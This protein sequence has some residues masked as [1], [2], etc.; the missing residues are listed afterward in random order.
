MLTERPEWKALQAHRAAMENVH[1]RGLFADQNRFDRFH[2]KS[3]GLLFDYSR[4]RATDET[5]KLLLNLAKACKIESW[6]DRMFSGDK[7][8]NSEDRAVLHTALRRPAG[9]DVSV[10]GENVMPFI[11]DT[12]R[13]MQ[14]FSKAV[15]GGLWTGHT[16]QKIKTIIN[17][18]IGGSDLGPL[19]VCEALAHLPERMDVRFVS[20][21]DGA[22]LN[23]TL[24]GLDPATTLFVIASKTFTTQETMANAITARGWLINAMQDTKA[25][26]K[27]FVALSTNEKAVAEFGIAPENMFPFR[28][29][30]GGRYSLWSAIGLSICLAYGFDT[31]RALLA[32]G[33]EM[34]R[35]F[36]EE[37]LEGNMPVIMA[38][39]GL[40]YRNFWD[41]QSYAVLPYAQELHRLPAFLQQLDM[42]S[43]GKSVDRDG[44]PLSYATGPVLLGEPG[45]N[46]QHSFMQLIHQGTNF[47]PCDF[48]GTL[49]APIAVG[50][51]HKLLL[52]NMAA[53]AQALMHGRTAEEAGGDTRRAFSGNRPSNILLLD[54][55]D[56]RH[57]GMLIALYEHKVFAQG[58]LWNINS[59]DQW[60][61]ELGKT[62]AGK[63]LSAV[64]GSIPEG[65][66]SA[67]KYLITRFKKPS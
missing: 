7:I 58:I 6:R 1:M 13:K 41:A 61:V 49:E 23:L 11:H 44:Q 5:I 3:G 15:R 55:L 67:T 65:I 63:I 45:T 62:L 64:D 26:A 54:R 19:M 12:L 17:I 32:G 9:E 28:D 25:V 34:D 30:V 14:S 40:W 35:H 37:P 8:N 36:Q 33:H 21:V 53:Q 51:H 59:F 10:D 20:N 38:L 4:N 50:D 16:G 52:A 24:R 22:H 27:H 46:S 29:W 48:I 18:G 47:V 60:G 39:L 57:L 43:N 2:I 31:F 42:E 56:A 66:D